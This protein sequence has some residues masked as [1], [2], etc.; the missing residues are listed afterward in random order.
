MSFNKNFALTFLFTIFCIGFAFKWIFT[1]LEVEHSVWLL[2]PTTLWVEQITGLDFNFLKGEGYVCTQI[3][4]TT[5]IDKSCS[6][7]NFWLM[8]FL[9]GGFT[10]HKKVTDLWRF[11]YAFLV[12]FLLAWCVTIVANTGRIVISI[13]FLPLLEP[14]IEY[15][16]SHLVLGIFIYLTM[17]IL[18]YL[19]WIFLSKKVIPLLQNI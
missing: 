4:P 18:Y 7:L 17:L 14:H 13:N 11:F 8:A 16:Q 9:V 12:S 5:I 1:N 19:G 15:A 10:L 6:G 3:V 2:Q